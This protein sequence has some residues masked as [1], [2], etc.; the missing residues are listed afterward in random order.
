M[1]RELMK[2]VYRVQVCLTPGGD[3]AA[4]LLV[5]AKTPQQAS[6]WVA[7]RLLTVTRPRPLELAQLAGRMKVLNDE[8]PPLD[9]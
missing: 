8:P 7:E 2:Q 5:A 3:V 1:T 4:D 9:I 6:A